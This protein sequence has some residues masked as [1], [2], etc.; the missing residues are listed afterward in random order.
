MK[1]FEVVIPILNCYK[2]TIDKEGSLNGILE[3]KGID[4]IRNAH[5]IRKE[6]YENKFYKKELRFN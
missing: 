5:R 2:T 6:M 3:Y 1:M 4:S